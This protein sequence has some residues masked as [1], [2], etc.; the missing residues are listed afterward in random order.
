MPHLNNVMNLIQQLRIL[1]GGFK[2]I[3]VK[4]SSAS[5]AMNFV[6]QTWTEEAVAYQSVEGKINRL[7]FCKIVP[8]SI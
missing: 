7:T 5:Q 3:N 8:S 4:I 6:I 1:R 2:I